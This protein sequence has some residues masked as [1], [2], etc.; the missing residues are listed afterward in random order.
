MLEINMGRLQLLI[1]VSEYDRGTECFK[2]RVEA[3]I[4][5]LDKVRVPE[6]PGS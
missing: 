2:E 4:I 6:I 5:G 1:T 3:K